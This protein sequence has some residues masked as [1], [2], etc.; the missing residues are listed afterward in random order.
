MLE[1]LSQIGAHPSETGC[2]RLATRTSLLR[3]SVTD[4]CN[5]RCRYC[6][7]AAGVTTLPPQ[8]ALCSE[9]L[10]DNVRWLAQHAFVNRVKLTGGEPLMRA[11][12][13][14][15]IAEITR[16]DE[17]CEVS[18]TTNG[19]LLA[20]KAK[21][22]KSAGLSRVNISLNSLCHERFRRLSRGGCLNHTLAG[23]DAAL[24]A[25]LLPLKLNVVL[26]R[27]TWQEDIPP[28]LDLAADRGI[29]IRFIELMRT[30]TERSWCESE[31]VSVEIV[32][33]WLASYSELIPAAT[34][35]ESHCRHTRM[36]WR[37]LPV[38]V[39]WIAPRTS[40]FCASCERLRMNS[41]GQLRRCLMDSEIL[42]LAD[43]RRKKGNDGAEDAFRCYVADKHAPAQMDSE[44]PMN[45]VGG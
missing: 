7:P 15:L 30:G 41:L 45:Q 4:H 3:L 38:S 33:N 20:K 35:G 9:E 36:R 27:S 19:S 39:G 34:L 37:D 5:F 22:L 16:I 26:L 25:G 44:W 10:L 32:E 24:E 28:L 23:I 6:M 43:I 8:R 31:F 42:D 13:E 21:R 1:A 11:D 29:E 2:L 12:L 18:M 14:A 17:I 40:P